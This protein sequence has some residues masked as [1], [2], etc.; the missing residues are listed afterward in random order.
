M[1]K[2]LSVLKE[3]WFSPLIIGLLITVFTKINKNPYKFASA[4][5]D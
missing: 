2:N 3:Y 5:V 1:K 4:N